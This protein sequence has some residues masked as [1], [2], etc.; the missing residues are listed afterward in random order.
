VK[1]KFKNW[2][3][4]EWT[5]FKLWFVPDQ[6]GPKLDPTIRR[7]GTASPARFI[8]I[9]LELKCRWTNI[10]GLSVKNYTFISYGLCK[11]RITTSAEQYEVLPVFS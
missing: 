2:Y 4:F 5:A 9:F 8:K 7:S 1:K 6:E 11:E 3:K 10:L